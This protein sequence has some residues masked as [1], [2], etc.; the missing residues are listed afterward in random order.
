MTAA[1]D[2]ALMGVPALADLLR[3]TDPPVLL[4][5]RWVVGSPPLHNAYL[6]G[7]IPGAHFC[8]LDADLADPPGSTGRH[9]LPDPIKLQ[10]RL[11]AWG[12]SDNSAVVVYDGDSSV[13]AARAWWVLRWAGIEQVRVLNG[14]FAA[15]IAADQPIETGEVL[16]A[17]GTVVVRPGALPTLAAPEVANFANQGRLIDVR[18]PERFRG[19]IE[20]MDPVAG[21]IPGA[22]NLPTTENNA[23]SGAL[24]PAVVLRKQFGAANL[25]AGQD[26]VGVYCGSG[27]TAAHAM[28]AMHEAGIDAVLYPGSWSEW[29][30]DPSRP[31]AIG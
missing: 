14:G 19:E 3:S 13:A 30:T 27:V 17:A 8:D 7:H 1:A 25:E 10:G 12:I 18:A 16:D 2:T 4:D 9:P 22:R 6:A 31:V 24:K 20:P 15:W 26:P 23:S 29:V 11:R 28:L 21:H 5:V